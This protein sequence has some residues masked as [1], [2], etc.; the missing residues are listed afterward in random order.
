MI[1]VLKFNSVLVGRVDIVV[2]DG[3][4][5]GERVGDEGEVERSLVSSQ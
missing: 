3:G 2:D 5:G 1:G 4:G